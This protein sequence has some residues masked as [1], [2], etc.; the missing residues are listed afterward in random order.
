MDVNIKNYN[1]IVK[2]SNI[3]TRCPDFCF[4]NA[5]CE[6]SNKMRCKMFYKNNCL[7]KKQRI[8]NECNKYK[9]QD[10]ISI[11]SNDRS[12]QR[13]RNNKLFNP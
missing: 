4:N 11:L 9:K 13:I 12:T 8:K 6:K 10:N 7:C 5:T 1:C 2:N 3:K